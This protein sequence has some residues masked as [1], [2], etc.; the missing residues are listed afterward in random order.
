MQSDAQQQPRYNAAAATGLASP[1]RFVAPSAYSAPGGGASS[2]ATGSTS[3]Y[4]PPATQHN[5]AGGAARSGSTGFRRRG[6]LPKQVTDLLKAWLLDHALHPYP[7]D[8]EKQR[9]CAA[10]GLTTNQ[11]S[12]WVS[13]GE[14]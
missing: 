4:I 6:K 8:E 2:V 12:N 5:A 13:G 11:V 9:L 10:T 3:T 7:T 1:D 14:F